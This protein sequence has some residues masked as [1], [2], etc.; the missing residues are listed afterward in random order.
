MPAHSDALYGAQIKRVF[1]ADSGK[2][3]KGQPLA[4]CKECG[5]ICTRPNYGNNALHFHLAKDHKD[6]FEKFVKELQDEEEN[7]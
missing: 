6:V 1:F 3:S 7:S 4:T 5:H 2:N